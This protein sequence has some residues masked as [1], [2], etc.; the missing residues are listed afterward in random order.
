M[1][2]DYEILELHK[3]L[4]KLSDKCSNTASKQMALDIIPSTDADVVREEVSKTNNALELIIKNA[5][6]EFVSFKDIKAI[7]N[8]ADSGA[9]LSL[10]E[11]IEVRRFLY[12]TRKLTQWRGEVEGDTLLDNN[13]DCFYFLFPQLNFLVNLLLLLID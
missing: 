7:V 6:P 3:I 12:Q 2:K 10:K 4:L 5:T 9:E 13:F 11:L 1:N 8:R